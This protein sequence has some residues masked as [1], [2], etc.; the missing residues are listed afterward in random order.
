[1]SLSCVLPTNNLATSKYFMAPSPWFPMLRDSS[2][3]YSKVYDYLTVWNLLS[4]I[5]L[6]F[7][8]YFC[9][10]F[11]DNYKRKISPLSETFLNKQ[12]IFYFLNSF[13][14][15]C[16]LTFYTHCIVCYLAKIWILKQITTCS[17]CSRN[18]S[19]LFVILQ[20]YEF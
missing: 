14:T 17:R 20:R 8:Y 6:R 2:W 4:I 16:V 18:I 5:I 12:F 9:Y 19:R 3:S 1:M 15:N 13:I 10:K 7:S 11:A